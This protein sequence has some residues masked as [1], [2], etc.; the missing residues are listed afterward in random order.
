MKKNPVKSNKLIFIIATSTIAINIDCRPKRQRINQST[1]SSQ[2]DPREIADEINKEIKGDDTLVNIMKKVS[3][4][5][6]GDEKNSKKKQVLDLIEK[7]VDAHSGELPDEDLQKLKDGYIKWATEL[8]NT[9]NPKK[10]MDRLKGVGGFIEKWGGKFLLFH[11]LGTM[12]KDAIKSKK[13]K[14]EDEEERKENPDERRARRRN[15]RNREENPDERRAR[16]KDEQGRRENP[17]ER[18]AR[19]KDE[20]GRRENPDEQ[21]ARQRDEQ[22]NELQNKNQQNEIKNKNQLE[23]EEME[24]ETNIETSNSFIEGEGKEIEEKGEMNLLEDF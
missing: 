24:L 5:K 10:F 9:K 13:N 22:K 14:K 4:M 16:Q 19:Q 18:R 8:M 6:D 12:T 17:D 21:R 2:K 20:Q 11:Q 1:K 3:Q 15:R 23:D 7:K